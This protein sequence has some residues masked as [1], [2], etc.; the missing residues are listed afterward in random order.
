M[1]QEGVLSPG[2]EYSE[3]VL[4]ICQTSNNTEILFVTNKKV[5][6]SPV[7]SVVHQILTTNGGTSNANVDNVQFA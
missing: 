4:T 3:I 5:M 6:Q 2:S 7:E 1:V